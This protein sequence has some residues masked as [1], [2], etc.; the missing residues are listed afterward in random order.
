MKLI[1]VALAAAMSLPSLASAT[2]RYRASSW[3][4]GAGPRVKG[5]GRPAT[6]TRPAEGAHAIRNEG[7]LDVVA[8]LGATDEV[9]LTADDNIL[10][11][12]TTSVEDGTLVVSTRGNFATGTRMRADVTLR[13][14][15]GVAVRGS[16]DVTA[17]ASTGAFDIGVQGSGD[18]VVTG[19]D[20][21]E[22]G[23]TIAGSGDVAASGRCDALHQTTQGSGD[24]HGAGLSC[25]SVTVTIQGSGDAVVSARDALDATIAGSGDVRCV[26]TP[27]VTQRVMGSGSVEPR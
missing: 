22:V 8:T 13:R 20:A 5:S 27:A 10:P 23:V 17:S 25:A 26:G 18:V 1:P 4:L 9:T 7:P 11:L 16:G 6:E 21:P 19:L 14:L 12:I 2:V 3:T 24:F 15:D